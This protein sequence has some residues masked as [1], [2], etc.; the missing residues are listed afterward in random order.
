LRALV[1]DG[2]RCVVTGNYHR[3]TLSEVS[4]STD[5]IREAGVVHTQ[6]AHIVP[7]STYLDVSD[8]DSSNKKLDYAASVLAVLKGF[9]YDVEQLNSTKVHSLYNAM[10][11]EANVHDWFHRLEIW[12][13]KTKVTN[14]YRIRSIDTLYRLPTEVTFTTPDNENLPVP[15]ETLLALH[16]TCAKV[17]HFSGAA[18]Y[19]DKLDRDVEHLGVLAHN[20][21]SGEVLS[22]ALLNRMNQII[23]VGV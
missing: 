14:R 10:T 3:D 9:G 22:S 11:M 6:C 15:S 7:E 4:A 2:F 20:G 1:R 17:A 5:E 13:E 23:G 18:E 16:A 8:Q 12:F 19:I 21:S